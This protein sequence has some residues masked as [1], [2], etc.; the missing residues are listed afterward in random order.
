MLDFTDY[1]ASLPKNHPLFISIEA[2]KIMRMS[3]IHVSNIKHIPDSFKIKRR[4]TSFNQLCPITYEYDFAFIDGNQEMLLY[5]NTDNIPII[6]SYNG[7]IELFYRFDSTM[8]YRVDF[9][10]SNHVEHVG[11]ATCPLAIFNKYCSYHRLFLLCSLL[12]IIKDETVRGNDRLRNEIKCSFTDDTV[13]GLFQLT[14]SKELFKILTENRFTKH[15]W[16]VDR[17][18]NLFRDSDDTELIA[19]ILEWTH[20]NEINDAEMLL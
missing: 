9:R 18:L 15:I 1:L 10:N 13:R 11:F 17:M 20:R 3:D 19:L 6:K 7:F 14:K 8:E 4:R 16:S 2:L 5:T 12:L